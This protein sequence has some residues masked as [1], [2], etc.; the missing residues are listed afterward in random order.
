VAS[1]KAASRARLGVLVV[2]RFFF[3]SLKSGKDI[4]KSE[5]L[6]R[7]NRRRSGKTCSGTR[8][9][10]GITLLMTLAGVVLILSSAALRLADR[11]NA[12]RLSAS[13]AR[14]VASPAKRA[15]LAQSPSTGGRQQ[16]LT[17]YSHLP[18][19][20]EPNQGQTDANVKFLAHGSGY[21]LYLTAHEAV[22]A[23]P[24]AA[25]NPQHPTLRASVV[26]MTL[27]G[28]NSAAEPAGDVQLPGKSNY[29]I[30]NDPAQWHRDIP[31]FARVRYRDV[32]PGVDLVYYGNQ[33]RLEYDFEVEPGAD[34]NVVALKFQGPRNL[35]IDT[36]G[37]LVLAVGDSNV[38]LQAPRVYQ[39][40]GAEERKVAGRFTL[41][42]QEKDEVG[43]QLGAYD[44]SRALIVDPVLVYSTYLGGSGNE[45]CSIIAPITVA[46]LAAPPAG[47]PAIAVD[48]VGNGYVAGST[49]STN[50]PATAGEYQPALAPGATANAFVAKFDPTGAL[51][52]ATYLGGNGVDYTAG[53]GVDSGF[54]VIVTGTTSSGDFPTKGSIAPF[55]ATPVSGGKHVFLSKLDPTGKILLYST[56]LSGSGVDIASGLA[57]DAGSNAY[58]TGTTTSTEQETG[59]PSTLGAI[60]T[61]PKATNQFFFTKVDPNTAG[62]GSVPYSTYIGGSNP[63]NGVTVGGG[64][65]VDSTSNAYI[66]G[67]T[68]FID[69]PLLNAYQVTNKGGL[70][71]FLTKINPAGVTGTQLLYSTYMGGSGDDVGY[72]VAV[73]STPN[74]YVV[75]STTSTDFNGAATGTVALQGSNGGGTDAFLA[76][77]GILCTLSTCTTPLPLDYFTYLGGSGTD[78]ANAVTIDNSQGAQIVGWTNSANFPLIGSLL[79]PPPPGKVLSN[80]YFARID[81]L[82][83]CSPIITPTCASTSSSSDFGGNG[84]DFGTGVALDQQG[85]TYLTGETSSATGFPLRNPFEGALNGPTDAFVTKLGPLLN[86]TM[87]PPT[88]IPLVVGVGSQV[89]FAYTITNNGEFTNGVYFIDY[90]PASGS[91]FVSATS[92][93][94]TCGSPAN[95]TVLCNIGTLNAAATATVTVVLTPVAPTLPG[96]TIILGNS[97]S[98]FVG[99]AM[100]ATASTS[101]TVN[102]FTLVVAP[103]TATVPAGVP[104]TFTATI[105]PSSNSGFPNSVSISCGSGLPVGATCLPGNNNPIPNLNSGPASSQLIINTTQ[106]VTTTTDLRRGGGPRAPFYAALLPVSGLA[107]FGVGIGGKRSRRRRLLLAVLM[108]GFFALV[109]FQAGCGSSTTT[110]TTTGTPAGTYPVTVNAVSGSA[111]RTT[112]VTLVVQ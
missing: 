20:F 8:I 62:S 95:Q 60:Q 98:A 66:T 16:T 106:R 108:G 11:E 32:Y 3:L 89:S 63:S 101:V 55:Q 83:N 7:L 12:N 29:F 27:A 47:C 70:D 100:L 35:R 71:A 73:D 75:G 18:L 68:N 5:E 26:R 2:R 97:G 69:M 103:A 65:A 41:R 82:A 22:L 74:A 64:V 84:A 39:K 6:V 72:G 52:F 14:F 1:T 59:F 4:G 43:F 107:L 80:A 10:L 23:L 109:I 92:S 111:T 67:G 94:G 91:T 9:L 21:G 31:Q 48:A 105:T 102:D 53:V 38:R 44:R 87:P 25:I 77:F 86:L 99:Q 33:G 76:K 88:A 17:A 54:D 51:Q 46:G 28:A 85:S 56:Y 79:P 93:P 34:P 104:A 110:T 96:G 90:L 37:D 112:V 58:V 42:G 13:D 57:L 50:F 24:Q 61:A 81:T 78:V 19:M 30:G 49:T 40:F 36:A 45:A 15:P